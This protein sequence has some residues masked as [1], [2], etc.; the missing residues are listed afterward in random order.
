MKFYAYKIHI[1]YK[2]GTEHEHLPYFMIS[3]IENEDENLIIE[4][5]IVVFTKQKK[6]SDSTVTMIIPISEIR[7]IIIKTEPQENENT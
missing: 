1:F 7:T 2:D 3:G 4:D 5:G 6:D